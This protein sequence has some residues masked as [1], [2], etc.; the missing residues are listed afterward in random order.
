M[1]LDGGSIATEIF[2]AAAL[3]YVFGEESLLKVEFV[4][5][6][7]RR[8]THFHIDC[9]SLDAEAYW[10]DWKSQQFAV[11]SL[12]DYTGIYSRLVGVCKQM[13]S[14]GVDMYCSPS[15]VAGRG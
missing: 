10:A 3:L 9:P 14:D 5:T 15:W 2:F 13:R 6:G 8:E 12:S 1:A 11:T 4:E 7:R